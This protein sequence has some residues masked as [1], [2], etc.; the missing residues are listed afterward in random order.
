LPS[1]RGPGRNVFLLGLTSFLAD[2]ASDMVMPLLP[3]FIV[4]L[5]GGAASIGT[6]E[7]AAEATA[8]L[9]KFLSGR[10]ADRARRLRPLAAM[11]YAIPAALRPLLALASSPWHV[12]ALR[13]GD[14]VGK[15]LRTSPRDKLLAASAAPE[16]LAEAFSFHRGMDHLGAAL[17]PLGATAILAIWPGE[18]RRVFLVASIPG[19]LAV[20]ALFLVRERDQGESPVPS[21]AAGA[22]PA[23]STFQPAP[24]AQG[25]GVP[26]AL[27]AT[28]GLFTLGNSSDALLLLRAQGAGASVAQLPLLWML[29]H[30]VRAGLSW[31]VGRVA[32][33]LGRRA[34]LGV[35]WLW[36]AACYL[37]F[38]F[39]KAP[40]QAWMVFAAYGLV[41]P[42]TEGS[43][44]A[45][46]ASAV[47]A[48]RRGRA[49]GLY[50]L[51]SGVGL[52]VASVL[53]GLLWERVSP[54]ASLG[55]SALLAALAAVGLFVF[56]SA[57]PRAPA[58]PASP[59]IRA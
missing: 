13:C 10:W 52:L 51:V 28:I 2:I 41:A 23:T 7:G 33:R 30:I 37:A 6:I 42:L 39:I 32:D 8:S 48:E 26:P 22:A 25:K 50:N 12:L 46:V 38:A 57:L 1:S 29:L 19:A 18:L 55:T 34:A 27:L 58:G 31:P 9:F 3:A 47:P 54:Q 21:A 4:A 36:Y 5:G 24:A 17:G 20:A 44:R 14:R 11:G 53:G 56:V 43:E 59:S 45:L 16:R 49:L 35:G 15:G 40:W